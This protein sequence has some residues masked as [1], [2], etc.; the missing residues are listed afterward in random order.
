MNSTQE[1]EL[2]K[3]LGRIEAKLKGSCQKDKDRHDEIEKLSKKFDDT[4]GNLPCHTQYKLCQTDI[5]GKVGWKLL[6]PAAGLFVML[7]FGAYGYIYKTGDDIHKHAADIKIHNDR[8][9]IKA[10]KE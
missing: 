1:N 7:L 3:T 5:K 9:I 8:E 2:F 6:L 10:L 4:V